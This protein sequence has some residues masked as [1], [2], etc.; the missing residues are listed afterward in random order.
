MLGFQNIIGHEEIV[1]NLRNVVRTGK[2]AH[3]YIFSGDKGSGKKTLAF[4]FAIALQCESGK[5]DIC[6]EC[7][8]CKRALTRNHPDIITVTHEKP[9]L[10]SVEEIKNQVVYDVEIKPYFGPYKIYVIPDAEL[11]NTQAQNALLKTI[12]EPPEYAIIM[13]LTNNADAMLPTIL[14]RCVRINMK[15]VK[16]D[17]VKSF[18][19]EQH[20]IP[21]YEAEVDTSFAQGNIGRAEDMAN[22]AEFEE[23]MKRTLKLLQTIDRMD[24]TELS[25]E[26]KFIQVDKSSIG[27]FLDILQFWFR[28]V[29]MF[30]ATREIDYLVFKQEINSIK[31]DASLRSYENLENIT[32]Q[33]EKTKARLKANVNIELA[34]ELLFMTIKEKK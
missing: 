3:S 19:M 31:K 10:I 32:S 24:P 17:E 28:D 34:L 8:S 11:L 1:N 5:G 12:E 21:E 30:K 16:D 13:L 22:S 20:Q 7:D 27:E 23:K 25:E 9:N 4:S 26:I 33:L 15:V 18:L 2:A 14:S 29:L 6:R